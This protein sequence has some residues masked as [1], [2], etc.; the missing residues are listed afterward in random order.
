MRQS[1]QDGSEDVVYGTTSG[2]ANQPVVNPVS[3]MLWASYPEEG[4]DVTLCVYNY[5]CYVRTIDY[6]A[7]PDYSSW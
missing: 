3:L 1:L 4:S 6:Y 2:D 5:W 7:I